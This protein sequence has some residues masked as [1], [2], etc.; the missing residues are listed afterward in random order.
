MEHVSL[1]S[2]PTFWVVLLVWRYRWFGM[3][4]DSEREA[5]FLLLLFLHFFFRGAVFSYV[6]TPPMMFLGTN[7]CRVDYDA[8]SEGL[9]LG[10]P[11]R[12]TKIQILCF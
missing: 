9:I 12:L 4:K 5:T 2:P 11:Q 8:D 7:I 3:A 6:K 1:E 10:V